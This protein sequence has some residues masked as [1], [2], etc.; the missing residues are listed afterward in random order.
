ME[1]AT[2]D[3]AANTAAGGNVWLVRIN[4]EINTNVS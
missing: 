4:D 2:E 3:S 1:F